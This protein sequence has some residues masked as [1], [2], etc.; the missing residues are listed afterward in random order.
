M[1]M[2]K[3]SKMG[4]TLKKRITSNSMRL[5]LRHK[6]RTVERAACARILNYSKKME[7]KEKKEKKEKT[8]IL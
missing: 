1:L 4:T 8:K 5:T 2:L 7:M 6:T 3:M